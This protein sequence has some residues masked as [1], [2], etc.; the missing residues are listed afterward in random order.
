MSHPS[1]P[2][3]DPALPD[4]VIERLRAHSDRLIPASQPPPGHPTW[5]ESALALL[6]GTTSAG[7][8]ALLVESLAVPLMVLLSLGGTLLLL[9]LISRRG[10]VSDDWPDL[11]MH[12]FWALPT[13]IAGVLGAHW[14]LSGV[15]GSG[16]PGDP[17]L[18]A[19]FLTTGAAGGA[20]IMR[21]GMTARLAAEHHGRYVLPEDFG[22]PSA[23]AGRREEPEAH[24]FTRLQQTTDRVEE[25]RR[26]L[27]GSF[28]A[29][30]TLPLL[31]EEE[32]RL[33]QELLRLRSLRR[34][35]LQ[36]RKDAVS[37]QV[38]RALE[39]QTEAVARAH[40]AL[41]QRVDELAA[42]GERVHA[43]VIA[44]Y[45]WEQCQEIADRAAD[46]ADLALTSGQD[47]SPTEELDSSMLSVRAA[48]S[49]REE[50]VREAVQAGTFLSRA[51]DD[52]PSPEDPGPE[53][54]A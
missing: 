18:A 37:D 40:R 28:D 33:S 42:Y 35:L 24:L 36:R 47:P 52:A 27:G 45:E 34:E 7:V 39:P 41:A 49:V 23:F 20:A 1:R 31:R 5:R 46:Y 19:L 32:W 2:T 25:G 26:V 30:R 16:L 22:R 17:A 29:S 54:P 38:T 14:V 9:G 10:S 44:H 13:S 3:F 53:D 48:H 6:L 21:P 12:A 15:L 43:A 51:M 11:I 4:S 8:L 50:L